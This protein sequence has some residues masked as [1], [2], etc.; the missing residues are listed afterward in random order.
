VPFPEACVRRSRG[1]APTPLNDGPEGWGRGGEGQ[2]PLKSF[3]IMWPG[4]HNPHNTV[5]HPSKHNPHSPH[6]TD[7]SDRPGGGPVPGG[8]GDLLRSER[9]HQSPGQH[10]L[11]AGGA[12][13]PRGPWPLHLTPGKGR[14]GAP[15]ELRGVCLLVDGRRPSP[16][17]PHRPEPLGKKTVTSKTYPFVAGNDLRHKN[18]GGTQGANGAIKRGT[19]ARR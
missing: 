17:P 1:A 19:G 10:L 11:G 8:V 5:A 14:R 13:P 2:S 18:I 15:W 12:V 6:P 16:S 4:K 9:R 3:G 7:P